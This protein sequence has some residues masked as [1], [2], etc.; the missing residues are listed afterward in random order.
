MRIHTYQFRVI[1]EFMQYYNRKYL[2]DEDIIVASM[3]MGDY[4]LGLC[5]RGMSDIAVCRTRT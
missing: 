4:N 2:R 3:L 1:M 5:L